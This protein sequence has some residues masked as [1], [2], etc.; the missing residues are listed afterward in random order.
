ME[1]TSL[2]PLSCQVDSFL[3]QDLVEDLPFVQ[4][5]AYVQF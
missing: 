1:D 4:K 3:K 5:T 2:L